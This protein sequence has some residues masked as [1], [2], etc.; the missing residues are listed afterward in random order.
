MSEMQALTCPQCGSPDLEEI[1][2]NKRRCQHCGASAL[3][4]DD[5]RSLTIIE[6][7]CP[8]CGF[9]NDRPARHCGQCG[10]SLVKTCPVCKAEMRSDLAFCPAC[11][12]EYDRA[13]QRR[14]QVEKSGQALATMSLI[15]IAAVM[16]VLVCVAICVFFFYT[17]Q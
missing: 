15:F 2:W 9:N 3:V 7:Q 8:N 11:G 14:Q 17:A 13:K 10:A 6:W 1:A 4:S 16:L 12:R 5:R